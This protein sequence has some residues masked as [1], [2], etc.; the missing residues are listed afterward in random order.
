[1]ILSAYSPKEESSLKGRIEDTAGTRGG[2]QSYKYK[3]HMDLLGFCHQLKRFC[4]KTIH[5][6]IM[7]YCTNI[8]DLE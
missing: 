2:C 6:E 1:M 7:D 5:P 8:I 3:Q 4:W